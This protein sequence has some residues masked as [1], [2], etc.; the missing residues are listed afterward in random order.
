MN[1]STTY[2]TNKAAQQINA[3]NTSHHLAQG[4]VTPFHNSRITIKRH[5]IQSSQPCRQDLDHTISSTTCL[6]GNI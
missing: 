6:W 4:L 5:I 1:M 3:A 2:A